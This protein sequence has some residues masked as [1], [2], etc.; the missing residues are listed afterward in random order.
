MNTLRTA[1]TL[2]RK[3]W[4]LWSRDRTGMA[5]GLA[6]PILLCG[7]FGFLNRYLFSADESAFSKA[8]LWVADEDDTRQSRDFVAGL[9]DAKT[10]S[11]HPDRGEAAVDAATLRKKLGDGEI[12]HGLVL[13]KGFGASIERG[14]LPQMT[15]LRDPDRTVEGQLISIGLMQA[16]FLTLGPDYSHVWATRSLEAA[17]LPKEWH[18]QIVALTKTFSSSIETMFRKKDAEERRDRKE[19]DLSNFVTQVLPVTHEDFRPPAR[20]KRLTYMLAHSVS[21]IGVMML[22]F[23][24]VACAS[25]LL[26]ERE[27]GTLVRLLLSPAERS[28]IL[29]GKFLFTAGIGVVQLTLLFTFGAFVFGVNPL[30]G[31]ATFAVI[32]LSVLAA[33]TAFGMLV[34]TA[35]RTQKQA[36]G[37]STIV[38]LVMSALGGA[39]FPLQILELGTPMKIVM[40]CTLTHWAVS[41][42]QDFFWNGRSF[43]APVMLQKIAV[44][45]GFT[46]V[47]TFVARKLFERRYV[48]A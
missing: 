36:D 41:S 19:F 33:V 24:L 29:W 48:D 5:L 21:G 26:R 44:L 23:G 14:E 15:M 31:F 40:S 4:R 2:A 46:L 27:S 17:G 47:A 12:H 43:L 11:I 7:V 35:A 39:W 18:D 13:P 10:L 25:L 16:T 1:F 20:P 42:Y 37:I 8:G 30:D 3:D 9:R 32:T 6:L 34:G 45:W 22:M 38:I 28:A